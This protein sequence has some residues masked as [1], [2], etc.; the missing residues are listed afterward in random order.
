MTLQTKF[1]AIDIAVTDI[2]QDLELVQQNLA[3]D[4]NHGDARRVRIAMRALAQFNGDEQPVSARGG[5]IP[6]KSY[7]VGE[8][9]AD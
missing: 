8:R 5:A 9:C 3:D 4:N 7:R 2:I 6:P 1:L